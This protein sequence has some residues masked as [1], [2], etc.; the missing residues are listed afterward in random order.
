[1]SSNRFVQL[2]GLLNESQMPV[3]KFSSKPEAERIKLLWQWST[4]K[5]MDLADWTPYLE[6]HCRAVANDVMNL[7]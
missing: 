7:G 5:Q 6:A 2:A 3:A 4:S 1:M